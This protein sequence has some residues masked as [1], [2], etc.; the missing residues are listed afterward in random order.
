M[1]ST[2]NWALEII[3][4]AWLYAFTVSKHWW[5]KTQ[6]RPTFWPGTAWEH[7]RKVCF[8]SASPNLWR[9]SR[10]YP[11]TAHVQPS[12]RHRL[13]VMPTAMEKSLWDFVVAFVLEFYYGCHICHI[14]TGLISMCNSAHCHQNN[15]DQ[16]S[17]VPL[18][19]LQGIWL[20]CTV[21]ITKMF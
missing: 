7:C 4:R 14:Q 19:S 6:K 10:L 5:L 20:A 17:L 8:P 11:G 15:C 18:W 21:I 2:E 16:F 3:C 9:F 1:A 13:Y 12:R